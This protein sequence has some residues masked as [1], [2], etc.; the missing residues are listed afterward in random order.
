MFSYAALCQSHKAPLIIMHGEVVYSAWLA[1]LEGPPETQVDL[2]LWTCSGVPHGNIRE[3][4]E[5]Q[6]AFLMICMLKKKEKMDSS[7]IL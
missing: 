3:H 4:M 2:L 5:E 6:T 1:I 7:N